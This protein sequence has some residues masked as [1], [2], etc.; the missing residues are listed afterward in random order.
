MNKGSFLFNL[1]LFASLNISNDI[2][3]SKENPTTLQF[4]NSKHGVL[5]QK[6][7]SLEISCEYTN[8]VDTGNPSNICSPRTR[9]NQNFSFFF[10][11]RQVNSDDEKSYITKNTSASVIF[12]RVYTTEP[13]E[14]FNKYKKIT[15]K[16]SYNKKTLELEK[17]V[18]SKRMIRSGDLDIP[19]IGPRGVNQKSDGIRYRGKCLINQKKGGLNYEPTTNQSYPF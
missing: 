17:V 3:N 7:P 14:I 13:S 18:I 11:E 16:Y 6:Q 2:V 15:E 10:N 12:G 4:F 9:P 19:D 1:V 5:K 8:C